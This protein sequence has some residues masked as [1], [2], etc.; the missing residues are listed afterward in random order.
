[1]AEL[2]ET[3]IAKLGEFGLIDRLT[4]GLEKHNGSTVTA[5]GDD[6][7]VMQ[8]GEDSD[9]RVRSVSFAP[10]RCTT[11]E[12]LA[13]PMQVMEITRPA[14]DDVVSPPTRSTP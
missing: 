11:S 4:A 7:A 2:P 13:S 10:L 3:E 5:V 6:A 1:M 8:Y 12:A 9:T 14:R